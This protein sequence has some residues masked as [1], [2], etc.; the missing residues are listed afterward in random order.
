MLNRIGHIF[1]LTSFGESHGAAIGGVIDGMP[2]GVNID[3]EAVQTQ[4]ARRK[5]GQSALTTSRREED[6][7][8]VLSGIF[9][10]ITT[11]TPIGFMVENTAQRSSDYA[12]IAA[13]YRPNHADYTYD[14]KYGIRDYRGGGRASARE[15][16]ARVVAGAFARQ[17][18]ASMGIEIVAFTSSVGE[19]AAD[20]DVN[21]V[22]VAEVDSTP[23][24]CPD[25]DTAEKMSAVIL[26]AK[27]AGDSV[28]GT[29]TCVI[30]GLPAGIGEPV[31]GRLNSE[32]AGAMM[33]IP[34]AKGF[35][36]G[37]GF[38]SARHRGSE[39]MDTFYT[40]DDGKIRTRTNNSGGI[41]GGISNGEN[42]VV[43][44]AFKPAPTLLIPDIPTVDSN[45]QT[46][47]VSVKGRHD[48]CVV[49]RA[50]PVVEA[51]AAIVCLDNILI[52]RTRR[53]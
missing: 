48:P 11:G 32:L 12:D 10:G 13:A 43:R 7:L 45:G 21:S 30:R 47:K 9:N 20:I 37:L 39:L 23:V 46:C 17:A 51:M 31:F 5:P 14:V 35:E 27:K 19:I 29:V 53:I 15:T 41:Q 33:S 26:D 16:I 34:A 6:N 8:K 28:G 22:S 18:M 25:V 52:N 4:L 44:V 49:P 2:A 1:S 24:R 36:V 50:V 38:E 40:D 42:V 3:L